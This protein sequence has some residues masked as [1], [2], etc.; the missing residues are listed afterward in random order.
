M[1]SCFELEL[2]NCIDDF[3]VSNVNRSE[4]GAFSIRE[5]INSDSA[6]DALLTR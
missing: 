1:G 6:I 4:G 2:K 5:N 3:V